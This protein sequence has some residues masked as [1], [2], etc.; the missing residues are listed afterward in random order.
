ML[1][2]QQCRWFVG[3]VSPSCLSKVLGIQGFWEDPGRTYLPVD[4]CEPSAV[5]LV[6]DPWGQNSKKKK[7]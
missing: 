3:G 2:A 6:G 4:W 5:E 1:N 7:K